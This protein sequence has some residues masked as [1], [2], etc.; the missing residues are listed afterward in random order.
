MFT[1]LVQTTARLVGREPRSATA[2]RLRVRLDGALPGPAPEVGESIAVNG[3]CLTLVA[4]QEAQELDFDILRETLDRTALRQKAAGAVV[5]VERALRV[6][7]PLGGHF[8]SG[9]VDG[10]ARLVSTEAAGPDV[11]LRLRLEPD[12]AADI[13]PYLLPKGSVALD[14][15]SLTLASVPAGEA[16]F[17]VH[18]IPHTLAATAL[19]ALR[20]GDLVNVEADAL[21]KAAVRGAS[22]TAAAEPGRR[23]PVTWERLRSAGFA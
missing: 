23:R 2:A 9:H 10:T 11:A 21:A 1:G 15:V 13:A 16:T 19:H 5:N 3:I 4:A 8:V 14:G 18:L 6:G 20:P 22:A 12:H 17:T 7:D